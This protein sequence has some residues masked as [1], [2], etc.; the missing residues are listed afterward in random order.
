MS[1][2]QDQLQLERN[3]VARGVAKTQNSFRSAEEG[4]RIA[5]TSYSKALT[6]EFLPDLV[7]HVALYCSETGAT[8]FGK[9][10]ALLRML[11]AD[12]ASLLALRG[13]FQDPFAE[14]PLPALAKLIGSMIEDEVKF[15]LFQDDHEDYYDAIIKDFK[16]KNTTHYRHRHRVLTFKMKEK[17]VAWTPW[18]PD[19][20]L[21]CGMIMLDCIL[22]ATDLIEKSYTRKGVKKITIVR[23]TAEA[24]TWIEKHKDHMA[25][26]SPEFMPCIIEPDDWSAMDVGGYYSPELR[27]RTPMVKT[28]SNKHKEIL[29]SADMTLVR[30]GLNGLQRTD[31]R[32]NRRVHDVVREIWK[33]DLRIGM[34]S[35]DPIVIPKSPFTNIDKADFTDV[36]QGMFDEWRRD[37][38]RLHTLENERVKQNFQVIRMIRAAESYRDYDAFWYVWQTDFRGRFYPATA[39][40]SPQ[41]PDMGKALIEFATP[42]MLGDRGFYWLKVHFA[43]LLGFD[44]EHFDDRAEYTDAR[45]DA[46]L[47]IA[48]DPLGDARV[49]WVN[50]DKP[51]CAL[52]AAFELADA[53]TNGADVT[54]NRISPAQDGTCNGLQHYAALLRDPQGAAATNVMAT[55]GVA[56]IYTQVGV[57]AAER[58]RADTGTEHEEA[59]NAWVDFLAG[60]GLP[61]KLAKKPVMTLPYGATQRSCTDS[62][63]DFLSDLDHALFPAGLRMKSS[64]F[65]TRHLWAAIGEVVTSA[66]AAM[67]WIQKIAATLA[68][69]GHALVWTTPS[70]FPVYQG[71]TKIKVRRIRTHLGGDIQMQI[72]DFT[73]ELDPR[74]QSS[75]SAPNFVHSLDATHLLFTVLACIRAGISAFAV[76]HDSYGTHAC[77]TDKLHVAIRQ[78]FVGMYGDTNLLHDFWQSQCDRTGVDLPPPPVQGTFDVR[79]V[80]TSPYFFG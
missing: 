70:G 11:D 45:R 34:G 5:D 8:R 68:K 12:K 55:G 71:S 49:H 22:K 32:V 76:I 63:L 36:Q 77:D 80:L 3:M 51:F 67:D 29:R 24:N 73:D 25:L 37:A 59:R 31:W 69:A 7:D 79:L 19:E 43:N 1:S 33:K 64:T 52:A 60:L 40:F 56:D 14:R 28:R 35:P 38:A 2:I 47:A 46:I 23:L 4:K 53:Y 57:I 18:T 21:H 75:G 48:A 39:G 61:R 27:R 65:L 17:D 44:K 6:R 9:F 41:G 10:R 62:V 15:S 54:P 30:E 26:L 20:K 16:R 74:R 58:V 42:K 72:G 78:S 50:A 13:V 66:R